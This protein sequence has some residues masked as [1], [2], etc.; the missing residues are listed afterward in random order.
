MRYVIGLTEVGLADASRVGRKAAV[1][2]ELL[3]AGFPVPAGF[4]ITVEARHAPP[5]ELARQVEAA[6]RQLGAGPVAVRSSGV[7]EDLAG[8]SYAGQYESVLGVRDLDELLDAV[9]TCWASAAAE[10]VRA[11]RGEVADVAM[12]VLVQVMVAA[13]AAGVVFSA[14]PVTGDRTEV[15]INAVAGLADR[16]VAGQ[17]DADQWTVRGD[18]PTGAGRTL[19]ESGVR[20]VARLARRVAAHAGAPQDIE[21]A[22][23]AHGLWLL[24][25]RPITALPPQPVTPVPIDI[26]VPAGGS[27]RNRA[28]DRP[29]TPLERS[30]FLP[31]FSA[32]VPHIFAYTTGIKP[33]AHDIG[34]WIYITVDDKAR[35]PARV[36]EPAPIE[37]IERWHRQWKREL[38]DEL[39]MLSDVD[40][41]GLTD[42]DLAGHLHRIVDLFGRLHDRYFR[43]TGAAIAIGARLNQLA[44]QLLGWTPEQTQRLRGGLTGDHMAATAGRN[45]GPT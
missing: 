16:L 3:G 31:V 22:R 37:L 41:A 21:W 32:A 34:G 36:D 7:D 2:G 45:C 43:L 14:N 18:Q 10:R 1:L 27:T 11:Y 25:A 33:T 9:H 44:G 20:A 30:V 12:G 19:D 40:L 6:W 39:A 23:D 42:A 24:Q 13:D 15:V 38:A 17:V 4:A 29:W 5:G 26:V 8:M 28:M 35:P